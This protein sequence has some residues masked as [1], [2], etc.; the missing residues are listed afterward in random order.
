M[1]TSLPIASMQKNDTKPRLIQWVF[2]LQEFDMEIRDKRGVRM[3]LLITY[4]IWNGKMRLKSLRE[5]NSSF[6]MNK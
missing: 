5:L 2:L 6:R 3:Y 1:R 4:P